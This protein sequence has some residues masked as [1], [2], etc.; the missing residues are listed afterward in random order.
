MKFNIII[1]F[2]VLTFSCDQKGKKNEAATN[3]TES[4]KKKVVAKKPQKNTEGKAEYNE[5]FDLWTEGRFIEFERLAF[6]FTGK[7]ENSIYLDSA[8]QLKKKVKKMRDSLASTRDSL[9]QTKSFEYFYSL[10]LPSSDTINHSTY[11]LWSYRFP[12]TFT[13]VDSILFN[14]KFDES[15]YIS[16]QPLSED[17]LT[18][19]VGHFND[20]ENY[21]YLYSIDSNFQV[22]DKKEVYTNGCFHFEEQNI[23]YKNYLINEYDY[24][25]TTYFN[26]D[27][28]FTI[29]VENIYQ[30]TDSPSGN[31]VQKAGK[32]EIALYRIDE[33][34]RFVEV[35]KDIN[36]EPFIAN[37]L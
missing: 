30:L 10:K 1:I 33:N 14:S 4:K 6:Q 8:K 16:Q 5:I 11:N 22:A 9:R 27:S 37:Q 2:F 13:K 31:K 32:E 19:A 15:W 28:T 29:K 12:N 17:F 24:K 3:I 18:L 36:T 21:I 23:R 34:G 25:K 26:D 7:Y 35:A 20:C